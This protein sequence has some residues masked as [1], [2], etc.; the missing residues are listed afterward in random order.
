MT[1]LNKYYEMLP[2]VL[3]IKACK[4][5]I[6]D[7]FESKM[8]TG[9]ETTLMFKL[10]VDEGIYEV[11]V[12]G[13]AFSIALGELCMVDSTKDADGEFAY[14]VFKLNEGIDALKE[15]ERGFDF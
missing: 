3:K 7:L 2:E 4:Q 12:Y 1:T 11:G 9:I 10:A 15:R 13:S 14:A 5:F 6:K 8:C